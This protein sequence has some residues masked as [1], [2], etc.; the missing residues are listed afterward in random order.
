MSVR[1]ISSFQAFWEHPTYKEIVALLPDAANLCCVQHMQAVW[2][3]KQRL[4]EVGPHTI[5]EELWEVHSMEPEDSKRRRFS[6]YIGALVCVRDILENLNQLIYQAILNDTM[7]ELNDEN[8]I[9]LAPFTMNMLGR[10]ILVTYLADHRLHIR[11]CTDVVKVDCSF[12]D[13]RLD[14]IA[15]IESLCTEPSPSFGEG[16]RYDLRVLDPDLNSFGV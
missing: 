15:R 14:T 3:M 1:Q 4:L 7:F 5:P 13:E 6:R 2:Q 12:Q 10:G 11:E 8:I 9:H 16:E